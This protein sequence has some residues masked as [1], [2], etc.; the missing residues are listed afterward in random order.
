MKLLLFV[1]LT[2]ILNALT[3]FS[4]ADTDF[5]H[6]KFNR[7]INQQQTELNFKRQQKQSNY[8]F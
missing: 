2:I 4:Q 1:G 5:L 8:S 7:R 6:E 3:C